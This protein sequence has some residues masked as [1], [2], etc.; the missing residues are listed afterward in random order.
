LRSRKLAVSAAVIVLTILV[1]IGVRVQAWY[2]AYLLADVRASVEASIEPYGNAL[3]AEVFRHVVLLE[4]LAAFAQ[5]QSAMA[6]FKKS[7]EIYARGLYSN[8]TAF[9]VLQAYPVDTPGLA[10]PV[11]SNEAVVGR[12]L[13]E[14]LNDQRPGVQADLRRA[15]TT[16]QIVLSDP[17]ELRQGGFGVVARRAVYRKDSFWGLVVIVL[18]MPRIMQAVDLDVSPGGLIFALTDRVG[19]VIGGQEHVLADDPVVRE[20]NLPDGVWHL[21]AAPAGGWSQEIRS[22]ILPVQVAAV[23]LIGLA[24]LLAFLLADRQERL[25]RAVRQRTAELAETH[26]RYKR[27]FEH[28]SDAMFVVRRDGGIIDANEAACRI[29][30]YRHDELLGLQVAD[31]T[32]S[33]TRPE[34]A[35][36]L[37]AAIGGSQRLMSCHQRKD[38]SAFTA[39]VRTTHVVLDGESCILAGVRDVTEREAM[40]RALQKSEA[41]LR[42]ILRSTGEGIY[43]VD[44]QGRCTLCNP[45]AALMLGYHDPADLVGRNTHERIHHSRVDGSALPAKECWIHSV[46][47]RGV[48]MSGDNE[49]FWR[50]DGQPVP[51][52]FWANPVIENGRVVGATVSFFDITKRKRV[53]ARLRRLSQ[54][55]EQSPLGVVVTDAQGKYEYVNPAYLRETGYEFAE[56]TGKSPN[57]TDP[58]GAGR[59]LLAEIEEAFLAGRGWQ[60]ERLRRRKN[61]TLFW[62]SVTAAPIF[63]E[64]GNIGG[65]VGFLENITERRRTTEQLRQAHKMQALGQLTGGVAHDFNNILSVILTNAEILAEDFHDDPAT[66]RVVATMT[67][68][69]QR[70][71]ELTDRLLAFSRRR[72]LSP[73]VVEL[74]P[75]V[76]EMVAM[77][78]RSLGELVTVSVQCEVNV[79]PVIVDRGQLETALLNL[80]INARDAMPTGG[81]LTVRLASSQPMVPSVKDGDGGEQDFVCISISDTGIGMPADVAERIFEPFFTTKG[82]GRGTGLGLSLVYGFV[83][84]SGGDIE[85]DSVEHKGTT[86]R[87]YLPAARK[88]LLETDTAK[89]V[90]WGGLAKDLPPLTILLAEDDDAVRAAARTLLIGCGHSVVEAVNGVEALEVLKRT[91]NINLLLTDVVMPGGMSGRDLADAAHELRADLKVLFTSGHAAGLLSEREIASGKRAFLAKPYTRESLIR[92]LKTAWFGNR[93]KAGNEGL[94]PERHDGVLPR[95]S[96][97]SGKAGGMQKQS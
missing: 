79:P 16:R 76:R 77:W 75:A 47:T 82:K 19:R 35:E 41:T 9:R 72:D 65:F 50:Q 88:T 43:A 66:S 81:L 44:L 71:A 60:G 7:F 94:G 86:F 4:G 42:L 37:A 24:T 90:E 23:A 74:E 3:S 51:V 56:L 92:A 30:R 78:R 46:I 8:G 21:A 95:R 26:T 27:L 29:Y 63:E 96:R 85:V 97:R 25:V 93:G 49:V 67:R 70:A 91:P 54:A 36:R 22:R 32:A 15:I 40:E 61:G 45:A 68:S 87:V 10:Y 12:S 33:H 89:L 80:A 6:D 13:E 28:N 73:E 17:Y 48:A 5:S 58:D 84:Q 20:V 14:L 55:V 59:S 1:V 31:L 83:R 62:A 38:G 39:E 2:K 34:M 52:E 18:D 11:E 69:V 53:E 64:D 57:L